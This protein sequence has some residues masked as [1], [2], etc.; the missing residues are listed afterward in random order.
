MIGMLSI[1]HLCHNSLQ[2]DC[3]MN[4][5]RRQIRDKRHALCNCSNAI[6]QSENDQ[7]LSQFALEGNK[8]HAQKR[9]IKLA[10]KAHKTWV[11]KTLL[12]LS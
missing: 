10:K 2:I 3:T 5:F 12:Q 8:T 6:I 4:S 9:M 7:T 11:I 1:Y